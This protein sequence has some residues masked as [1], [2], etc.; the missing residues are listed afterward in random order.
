MLGDLRAAVRERIL[1]TVPFQLAD[2]SE[3]VSLRDL[4]TRLPEPR[5]YYR[6]VGSPV[7]VSRQIDDE[8]LP[9]NFNE[10]V[11]HTI[12][13]GALRAR[14]FEVVETGYLTFTWQVPQQPQPTTY[15][16]NEYQVIQDSLSGSGEA[17]IEVSQAPESDLN[18]D[19][20]EKLPSLRRV[21]DVGGGQLRLASV[22]GSGRRVVADSSGVRYLNIEHPRVKRLLS[23]LPDAVANPL[24]RRLLQVY[25]GLETLSLLEARDVLL[26]LLEDQNLTVIAQSETSVLTQRAVRRAID[27]LLA[28]QKAT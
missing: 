13:I 23:A 15:Q 16:I 17:V 24:K 8:G 3:R 9:I 4:L 26:D 10:E 21:L 25:L 7:Y 22:P 27:R 18:F 12:R 6:A 11:G 19:D 5:L 14:G 2:S 20:F 1:S 28:E